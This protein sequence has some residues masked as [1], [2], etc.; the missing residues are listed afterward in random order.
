[1]WPASW[2][3]ALPQP[4]CIDPAGAAPPYQR[5][6]AYGALIGACKVTQASSTSTQGLFS[7]PKQTSV[8]QWIN[9]CRLTI[10]EDT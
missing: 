8:V 2:L 1:M 10:F 9:Q 4:N 5:G 3:G 6:V 7:N